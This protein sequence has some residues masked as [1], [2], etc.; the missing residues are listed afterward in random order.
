MSTDP[1]KIEAMV[2]WPS[3]TDARQLRGFLELFGYYRKFIKNYGL[4]SRPL[5]DL[6]K[7]DTMFHWTP[8]LQISFDTLKQALVFAPV[9]V[10]PDFTKSFTIETDASST[11]IGAVLS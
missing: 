4:L 7:K 9:L 6:L 8:Q 1:K 3:P 10:L 5:T 11:G 2:N